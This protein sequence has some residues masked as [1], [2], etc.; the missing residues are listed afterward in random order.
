MLGISVRA[1]LTI[2]DQP[3][4]T[5]PFVSGT[6]A[7]HQ[8][9]AIAVTGSTTVAT[10][11]GA[12]VFTQAASAGTGY[13]A[14][15]T[16]LTTTPTLASISF[17]YRQN[18]NSA[19]TSKLRFYCGSGLAASNA[20][21]NCY[22][23]FDIDTR[24]TSGGTQRLALRRRDGTAATSNQNNTAATTITWILN[25]TGSTQNYTGPDGATYSIANDVADLWYGNTRVFN[26]MATN[27]PAQSI[28]DFKIVVTSTGNVAGTYTFDDILIRDLGQLNTTTAS[29]GPY[30]AG[31]TGI[32]V[33]FT[34]AN[35]T[36]N[37]TNV[38]TAQ[39]SD[40]SGSFAAPTAIGTFVSMSVS[41]NVSCTIP[42]GTAAGTG[43]RIRIVSSDNAFAGT[44]NGSDI[45]INAAS[46]STNTAA[47]GPVCVSDL[48]SSSSFN[49][50]YGSVCSAA[51]NAG[52]VFSVQLSNAS[53]SFASPITIGT[54]A[55]TTGSGSIP[56]RIPPG[57]AAGTGYRIRVVS[58]SP[59]LVSTT[60]NGSNITL[61]KPSVTI[62]TFPFQAFGSG[63][64]GAAVTATLANGASNYQW[65]YRL[66]SGGTIYNLAGRTSA[67]YTPLGADFPGRGTYY[68][69]CTSIGCGGVY[70]AVSE[71]LLLEI[72]CPTSTNLVINGDF[73]LGDTGF[74][75]E[76]TVYTPGSGGCAA[77]CIDNT[78]PYAGSCYCF[79][80]YVVDQ[81]PAKYNRYFCG[82]T[83]NG[84][85]PMPA[86]PPAGVGG[87]FLIGDGSDTFAADLWQQTVTVT[88]YTDYVFTFW[89]LSLTGAAGSVQE[90]KFN[91]GTFA[92]CTQIGSN[93]DFPAG[94]GYSC[95]WYKY[96]AH[97]NSANRTSVQLAI[98]N[99]SFSGDGNDIAVDGIQFYACTD[100][101][102]FY[103]PSVKYTWRGS[104]N[105]DWT[106]PDNWGTCTELP[107][108]GD[109]VVVPAGCPNYPVLTNGQTANTQRLRIK[110]GASMTLNTGA[111]LNVCGSLYQNGTLTA[112]TGS[113]I[114]FTTTGPDSLVG[115]LNGSNSMGNLTV[116]N[117]AGTLTLYTHAAAAGNLTL[118]TGTLNLNGYTMQVGGNLTHNA[119][120]AASNGTVEFHTA[121]NGNYTRGAGGTGNFYNL[122]MNKTSATATVTVG[123]NSNMMVGNTLVLSRGIIVAPNGSTQNV[124][125]LNRAENAITNHSAN[126]YIRGYLR[127]Y[128]NSLGSYDFPVGHAT[129]LYQLANI[130][131]YSATTIDNLLASFATY[132][133]LPANPLNGITQCAAIY[134]QPA[135]DNGK[136]TISAY[137]AGLGQIS[138]DGQYLATL[139]NTNYTNDIGM[140]AWRVMKSENSG[141]TWSSPSGCVG[142]ISSPGNPSMLFTGFSDFGTGQAATSVLP[143][144]SLNFEA[145]PVN[146]DV[147]LNWR[148]KN[149]INTS[150]YVLERSATGEDFAS[151]ASEPAT[152]SPT[153]TTSYVYT[154]RPGPYSILYYRLRVV[155][156]D[157]SMAHSNIAVVQAGSNGLSL[158]CVPNPVTGG[159]TLQL[160]LQMNETQLVKLQVVDITG[161]EIWSSNQVRAAGSQTI[162]IPTQGWSQGTY[163]VIANTSK[164]NVAKRIVIT[165]GHN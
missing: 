82:G 119:P 156:A 133:T 29:Y 130:N 91:F 31:A 128:I 116:N 8:F 122:T 79:Q 135:L 37:V 13:I 20:D 25:N 112:A 151:I 11:A 100:G 33:P 145:T 28:T 14:R 99:M 57:T 4:T 113:T 40:A 148:S 127:R 94:T 92:D 23:R 53:G 21:E 154:D 165:S 115:S 66:F 76:Y 72:D 96:S 5:G 132:G 150:Y 81:I 45:T 124:T 90:G 109:S 9:N 18:V 17:S 3:F 30:C 89:A 60:N 87:N 129:K 48:D 71:E 27:Q 39:L 61:T 86:S 15:T 51:F 78:A 140:V 161:R 12:A 101:L 123:A 32:S 149:E 108:C 153:T 107:T 1:Q 121:A 126:S 117:G 19:Q 43:Y 68:L 6:P 22:A 104:V 125:V 102:S 44:D 136:W 85:G 141:T 77:G 163:C 139:Y 98:R 58:S 110:P 138:G 50:G 64:G 46:V 155:D 120:L 7:Q 38:F 106:N 157:G 118:T 74:T 158:K 95:T 80:K 146:N 103:P 36:F 137:N 49:V 84:I 10:G 65:G 143:L 26:G 70:N 55:G 16:D 62:P 83:Q 144:E 88:P 54:L 162:S 35:A 42:A 147:R 24:T 69:V 142:D 59:A 114:N 2:L 67:S 75:S 93:L 56:S 34:S 134:D 52:N 41:G 47:Y 159:N 152:G 131:F 111:I 73:S 105:S 97:W 63:G 160:H 164:Q